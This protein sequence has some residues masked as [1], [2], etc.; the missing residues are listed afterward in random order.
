MTH[1]NEKVFEGS[2]QLTKREYFAAMIL[3]GLVSKYNMNAPQ[4]QATLSQMAVELTDEFIKHL[5]Q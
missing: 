2:Y 3:Q 1:G 4:D 5:N